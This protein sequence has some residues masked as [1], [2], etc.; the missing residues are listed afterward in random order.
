MKVSAPVRPYYSAKGASTA[1]YDLVT[2]K[3]ASLSGDIDLYASLAPA[4]GSILELGAGTGRV[5][6]ALAEQGFHVTGLDIAP[7]MLDQANAKRASCS[8][9][10]ASRLHFVQGDMTSFTLAKQFDAVICTFYALAHLPVGAAW[11]NTFKA[12]GRHLKPG[13]T[14]AF[15]LPVPAKMGSTVPP[16]TSPVFNYST[17]DGESLTLFVAKRTMT[18]RVGRM[19]LILRYV[20]AG[21][22]G[23]QESLE[24]LT[25]YSGDPDLFA[26]A[27]GFDRLGEPVALGEDGLVHIYK[28]T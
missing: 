21:P 10:V 24:R 12:V 6:V 18:D 27:S 17:G 22:K 3:D 5:A 16:P 9:E 28:R 7:A 4:G 25:L 26:V 2:A 11:T 15:H 20:H 23:V 14:A 13:G 1:F 19:D 8:D